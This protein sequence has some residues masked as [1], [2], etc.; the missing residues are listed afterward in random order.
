MGN[1]FQ[2]QSSFITASVEPQY[3]FPTASILLGHYILNNYEEKKLMRAKKRVKAQ[4]NPEDVDGFEGPWAGFQGE[5]ERKED[6]AREAAEMRRDKEREAAENL[7][8]ILHYR[9]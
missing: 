6:F 5:A 1:S 8:D 4:N 2:T 9:P 3:S 7:E